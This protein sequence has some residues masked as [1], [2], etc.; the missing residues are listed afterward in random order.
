MEKIL[1]VD[2]KEENL[3]FLQSLFKASGYE[4]ITAHN[5]SEALQAAY[6][7]PPD[8]VIS[9]ILMPVMDGFSLCRRWR[10]EPN[11]KHIPFAF[12][13]ATYTDSKDKEF[14]LSVG[15]D[16]FFVKPIEPDILLDIVRDL[17]KQKDTGEIAFRPPVP[18]PSVFLREYNATLIRKLE[19][20]VSELEA[21]NHNLA[22][23]EEFVRTILENSPL[24]IVATGVDDGI[25]FANPAFTAIFGYSV[26]EAQGRLCSELINPSGADSEAVPPSQHFSTG[27]DNPHIVKRCRKDGE[28]LDVELFQA[29]LQVQG[30][31][32]GQ[33]AIYRDVTQKR[34]MEEQLRQAQKLEAV[35]QL[36]AGVAHD[37]NNLLS[38]MMG[39][40]EQIA[41]GTD[42]Q[43]KLFHQADQIRKA[44][45]RAATL[46]RQL[47]A[48]SRR[49]V[50]VPQIV[51]FETLLEEMTKMLRRVT[52]EDIELA[53]TVNHPIGRVVADPVQIEQVIL[54]LVTNACD[55]MPNGGR[56][57]IEVSN[58]TVDQ[59]RAH[60]HPS[61]Q[62]NEYVR[63]A[64]IDTGIGMDE[65][66]RAHI[67]EPFFTTKPVGS[68]TGLG[69]ASV[70]GIVEQSGGAI[71]VSSE[72]GRGS[73]FEI[74]LPV[75]HA[76]ESASPQPTPQSLAG[77][78]ETVLVV[79]DDETVRA[80]TCEMLSGLG[81]RVLAAVSAEEAARILQDRQ[82]HIDL[83]IT[84]AIMPKM[85]G[86][87][88]SELAW[89]V[90]PELHVLFVSGYQSELGVAKPADHTHRMEYLAK[91]FSQR[92]LGEALRRLLA[93]KENVLKQNVH[94]GT[95]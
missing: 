48:F 4:V 75:V 53:V 64:V 95:D 13:T 77:G 39:Y 42:P 74:F 79:E 59:A 6:A 31:H 35:G 49:Q 65:S 43:S 67:F 5:G 21:S 78:N 47:L 84:D 61:L 55:A 8:V 86:R 83:L 9:D 14:G 10:I 12:Y 85:S 46:T 1:V 44:C 69:L 24:P 80:L 36:A 51:S 22:T 20:K 37:F 11:L 81:Y 15:A 38:V 2:D 58:T 92:Q 88:L 26:S 54:N 25:I 19:N 71:L 45:F 70:H 89:S 32:I 93:T 29:P 62:P 33:L 17:L 94:Q 63:L 3:Y 7:T 30:K 68:G 56:L 66:T 16:G 27:G 72:P 82:Q 52:R 73:C 34:R 90:R 18:E 87:A 57:S 50:L 41:Y 91:P 76:T 23:A 40:S 60:A 28:V